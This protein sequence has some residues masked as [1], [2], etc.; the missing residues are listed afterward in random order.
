MKKEL[1]PLC[2][3]VFK[4]SP[5]GCCFFILEKIVYGILPSIRVYLFSELVNGVLH[6]TN[7]EKDW[8]SVVP[9]LLSIFLVQFVGWTLREAEN[10]VRPEFIQDGTGFGN[11]AHEGNRGFHFV[12]EAALQAVGVQGRK[13]ESGL[14][15]DPGFHAVGVADEQNPGIGILFHGALCQGQGGIYVTAGSAGGNA[16]S[17]HETVVPFICVVS[18][19]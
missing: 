12:Q 8:K 10:H 6:I 16:D 1:L 19:G 5:K 9:I 3:T 4:Y 11:G 2:G 17:F 13:V 7:E 14:R 15:H 18:D